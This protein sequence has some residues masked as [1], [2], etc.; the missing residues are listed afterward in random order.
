[1]NKSASV[2]VPGQRY[3]SEMEPE[4]GLGIVQR[5]EGKRL[6]MVFPNSCTERIYLSVNPP[7]RRVRF[8]AGDTIAVQNGTTSVVSDTTEKNGIMHYRCGNESVAETEL[9]GAMSYATPVERLCRHIFDD[10]RSFQFRQR[11]SRFRASIATSPLRGFCGGAVECIPHQLYI[12]EKATSS[13][14]CRYFLADEV[15][16]GKTIEA[17][18]I[19]HRLLATGR[20]SRALIIVPSSL[21]HQWFVELFRRF[22]MAAAVVNDDFKVDKI[23]AEKNPFFSLSLVIISQED[24][25][26]D[27]ILFTHCKAT[28]WDICIID[29]AHHLAHDSR[30]YTAVSVLAKQTGSLLLLS[31]TPDVLDE[32]SFFA[33]MKLLDPVKFQTIE[34]FRSEKE[35]YIRTSKIAETLLGGKTVSSSDREFLTRTAPS[36]LHEID[37]QASVSAPVQKRIA[38]KLVDISGIGRTMFRNS[39]AVIQGFPRR[40]AKIV[41]L[42]DHTAGVNL[43]GCVRSEVLEWIATFLLQNRRKKT[44]LICQTKEKVME[45]RSYLQQRTAITPA[46]FHEEMSIIQLDKNAAWFAEPEGTNL[47]ISSEI[48]SEGRNFQHADFLLLPDMPSDPEKFEQRIGRLDRIGRKKPVSIIVVVIENS[49]E[50]VLAS[51]YDKGLD[52]FRQTVPGAHQIGAAFYSRLLL[53]AK[54]ISRGNPA[55]LEQVIADTILFKKTLSDKLEKGRNRLLEL[56]SFDRDKASKLIDAIKSVEKEYPLCTVMEQIYDH[57]GIQVDELRPGL[58]HLDFELVSD[59]SFPIPAMH[60]QGMLITYDRTIALAREDTEFITIDHP[61]VT[62]AFDIILS[63]E[64]GNCSCVTLTGTGKNGFALETMYTLE[65]SGGM[66]YNPYHYFSPSP[67]RIVFDNSGRDV[68]GDIP[69][70]FIN[71]KSVNAGR[72]LLESLSEPVDALIKPVLDKCFTRARQW[73][74]ESIAHARIK[75]TEDLHE[76]KK[77]IESLLTTPVDIEKELE[78]TTDIYHQL[79]KSICSGILRLDSIRLIFFI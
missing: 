17:C 21:L 42:P 33:L 61:M 23:C 25:A 5:I 63:R 34:K 45:I 4:L 49:L 32:A 38:A 27:E 51:W 46:L 3:I 41:R 52:A 15:G 73:Q 12:S 67:V 11:I 77:R 36:L 58:Y 79:E 6:Y 26:S 14:E 50:D 66:K 62:G 47:L 7:I 29:E 16:L 31:A 54:E 18:L 1:M 71:E 78:K 30:R 40:T 72:E 2:F 75:I 48:G 60:E 35:N 22:S 65:P 24:I 13:L 28:D 44:L 69:Y 76:A 37:E 70:D 68:T 74:Q 9:T 53:A 8:K 59:H 43:R 57:F 56:S 64:K 55:A 10:S 39:R 20:I 19:L